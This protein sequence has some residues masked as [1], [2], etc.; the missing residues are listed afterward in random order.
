MQIDDIMEMWKSD[1]DISPVDLGQHSLDTAKLHAKYLRLF[2]N[3]R[4][5]LKKYKSEYKQLQKLKYEYY[6][7]TISDDDLIQ[8]NWKPFQLKILKQDIGMYIDS[9]SDVIKVSLKIGLQEEKVE[10]LDNIIKAINNRGFQ[11]KNY[12]DFMKFTHGQ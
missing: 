9:D 10:A 7:G 4:L 3:E 5:I 12:I 11:I 2:T 8:N 1:C 6:S